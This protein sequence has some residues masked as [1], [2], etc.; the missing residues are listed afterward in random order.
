MSDLPWGGPT[1][2]GPDGLS[3]LRA[4]GR[5]RFSALGFPD[6]SNEAW[7]YTSTKKL[8][9]APWASTDRA[10]IEPAALAPWRVADAAAEYVFV[11]GHLRADLSRVH[12]TPL[13]VSPLQSATDVEKVGAFAPIVDGFGA[14]SAA[15]AQDGLVIFAPR[16]AD[17][18][19]AI[20]IL[21]VVTG[22]ATVAHPRHLVIAEA[23]AH[24]SVLSTTAHAGGR[25]L[26]NETVEV[27]LG[28]GARVDWQNIDAVG[29]GAVIRRTSAVLGRDAT[30]RRHTTTL[31]G[32]LVRDEVSVR[33]D[34]A[35][36]VTHLDGLALPSSGEHADHRTVIEHPAARGT[37]TESYRAVVGSGGRS[38]FDGTVIV[39]KGG[40]QT[41]A[42][43]SSRNLLLADDAEADARPRL[44]IYTD[45]VK[46]AHGTTVGQL[47]AAQLHYLRSRG[48]PHTEART[49]LIQAFVAE[50]F[51]SIANEGHRARLASLVD[52]RLAT[53][54]GV[55]AA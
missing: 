44:E 26:V 39:G 1:P 35:G 21:H 16:G 23:N 36:A 7:H 24:V 54:L 12:E 4:T 37:T 8:L 53:L 9:D 15:L 22:E 50:T 43:Q 33:L 27:E 11:N 10:S 25:A 40:S 52:A 14:L 29:E 5:E 3:T 31:S 42:R 46:C 41:D 49:M 45:D 48:I 34:G 20:H 28:A 51:A 2:T 6:T 30:F 47:D 32:A 55:S 17:G 19:Q 38:V 13:R 18:R